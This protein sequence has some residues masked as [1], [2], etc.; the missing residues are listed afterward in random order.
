MENPLVENLFTAMKKS[1]C[2]NGK[3]ISCKANIRKLH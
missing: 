2:F 1:I 3:S